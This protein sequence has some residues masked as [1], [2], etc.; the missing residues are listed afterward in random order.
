M[1]LKLQTKKT[2]GCKICGVNTKIK[3]EGLYDNRHGYPGKFDLL[4]CPNCGFIQTNPR[5]NKRQISNIYSEYYPRQDIDIESVRMAGKNM[6]SMEEVKK[7]GLIGTCYFATKKGEKVLDIGSGVGYSLIRIEAL[8]GEAWGLDPDDNARKIAKKLKLNFHHG[9]IDNCPFD[10]K[11]FDLITASQVLEHIP[12]PLKFLKIT[13]EF[14]KPG[15]RILLSFPNTGA[16]YQKIWR[17]MWLHWHVPYHLNHFNKKSFK[18]LVNQSGLKIVKIETVTPI[19]WTI[20][21]IKSWLNNTKEGERDGMWDGKPIKVRD[22]PKRS[23]SQ[24]LVVRTL[25]IIERLFGINRLI[26]WLGIGESFVV[27]LKEP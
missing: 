2:L 13:R 16:L 23:L 1:N 5:L 22:E 21:Q 6:P 14:L 25:P 9:F 20:L 12:D 27:E 18:T 8:G 26:D 19:L 24:I 7:K 3:Y 4:E 15:G 11:S 10:K 17:K